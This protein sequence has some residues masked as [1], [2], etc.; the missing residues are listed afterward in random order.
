MRSTGLIQGHLTFK[1]MIQDIDQH[2]DIINDALAW[3]QEYQKESFHAEQMKE[4]RRKLLKIRKALIVNCSAAAYGESQVGKSYLMSSLLSS[5][6]HPFVIENDGKEYSFIDELNPSGGNNAKIE[7]TGVITRFT[8]NKGEWKNENMVKILNLSVVDIILLLTDS[9]YNDIRIN[10]DTILPYDAINRKLE[11]L[12]SLWSNKK[13]QHNVIIEDDIKDIN[14]YI[15]EV[16][17]NSAAAICQSNFCKTIA[18]VI[19]YIPYEKWVDVFSL[20]WNQNEEINRLFATLINAYKKLD[21]QQEVYVPFNAVLRSE[22]T[23]LKIEWLDTVCGIQIDT[24]SDNVYTHVFDKDGHLL[25]SNFSKGDLSALIAE[26]TFEL[27]DALAE[28]RKFLRE[29]DLLDFPGARSREKYKEKEIATVLPKMLRRGKVA[30]LFNKYSR[31]LQISSVLFC[32]HNDQK[33]EPTIGE[34]INGWIEENIGLTP[35]ERTEMLK[36]THGIAPLFLVATKFNIDLERTKTDKAQDYETLDKHWNRF[37]TVF[38]EIIKPNR[39][40]E[41]WVVSPDGSL[42]PFQNIYPLRDFYW[43]GK[44]GLFDGYSD[45]AL[46]SEESSI[47]YHADFPD[48]FDRLKDSFLRNK[49][50]RRHFDNPDQTW[51]DVATLNNDGSKAIIKNLDTISSVLDKARRDK[52]KRQLESLK[53]E[54]I[55]ALEVFY[56]PEDSEAKNK[57]VRLIAGDIR[58]SL[59]RTIASNPAAFGRILDKLM[60]S[61]EALRNIA[62]NIIVCH[63]DTP[64][65]FSA[66]NFIRA[67]A[68]I[69]ITADKTSNIDKLLCYYILDDEK[70]LRQF[71]KEQ[72]FELEDVIS[73]EILTL[74]TIGDV[75]TKHI[76]DYWVEH[77]NATAQELTSVLPHADEVVF[78]LVNLFNKLD[79]RKSISEKITR[80]TEIFSEGEQ[81][82]AIGDYASLTFNNFVSFVGRNY[83]SD[84][85]IESLKVKAGDCNIPVDFSPAGWNIIRK[86]QPLVETLKIF[87]E[88]ASIVNKGRIDIEV[89]RKLPFWNN[90]Q[91]WE[92]FVIIGLIYSSDIS[93]CDPICNEKIKNL[94]E[95]SQLLYN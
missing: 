12:G 95:R 2:I 90:Y 50:V 3:A 70:D 64:K 54:L 40:L 74:S 7:S 91:R 23:L 55:K 36:C 39:W 43:S 53:Q 46:K 18:P 67:S 94:I 52:Y 82:N 57:K 22:G 16:I 80:Y 84:D 59:D 24:G 5:A 33:A 25:A 68:G 4:Y 88:A 20:L 73:K 42:L 51:N 11:E 66:I 49:F 63:T 8:I 60:V 58:R 27:P 61:P 56:E 10:P 87:D 45:G 79:V 37:D 1:I 71:L 31:S 15:K 13:I 78:M 32:H 77:L 85:E 65:D 47:H 93:H 48:Y 30:Y 6:N 86:P 35:Q 38:P 17:G 41:E 28:D 9:Y 81:P 34:T 92:N 29:M 72:G 62:Y 26:L 21:F 76:V 19:Q 69:D 83:M 44:N 14:D 75:I 89:L